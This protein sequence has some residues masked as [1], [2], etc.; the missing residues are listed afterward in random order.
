M[1]Q[2]L[3]CDVCVCDPTPTVMDLLC[4][5]VISFWD[6]DPP[7]RPHAE[8]L[9]SA[10]HGNRSLPAKQCPLRPEQMLSWPLTPSTFVTVG[11]PFFCLL[12]PLSAS[13]TGTDLPS[14]TL[15]V[16][17]SCDT[18]TAPVCTDKTS[19][20]WKISRQWYFIL[21]HDHL[22]FKNLLQH[23]LLPLL[24]DGFVSASFVLT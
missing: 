1:K 6:K 15:G 2:M 12:S 16:T 22:F 14:A 13:P 5:K 7:T 11:Q 8:I 4:S 10:H 18:R 19:L 20:L 9:S 3:C 21:L 17:L 24:R 23:S